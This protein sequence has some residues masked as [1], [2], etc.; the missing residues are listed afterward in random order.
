MAFIT[1]KEEVKRGVIIFRRSDVKHRDW[2]CRVKLP[3]VD[4]Y[5]IVS[6]KTPD[7]ALARHLAAEQEIRV[8]VRI[9]SDIPMFNHPFRVVAKEMWRPSRLAPNVARSAPSASPS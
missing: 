7:V 3:K 2:Y 8:R 6:L 4:R 9:E 5:K 1:D